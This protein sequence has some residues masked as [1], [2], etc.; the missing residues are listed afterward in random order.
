MNRKFSRR[1]FLRIG[2]YA[3]LGLSGLSMWSCGGSG[4]IDSA[5]GVPGPQ[6]L[7]DP[8]Y[9]A[10]VNVFLFGGNDG[11]NML[12]PTTQSKYDSYSAARLNLAVP[13]NQLLALNGI[14][15]DGAAYGAHPSC[16]E[17][18]DLFNSN[19]AALM[20]NVG[21]LTFP[22]V[23]ADYLAD[24]VPPRLF[25]H[26]DQQDQWQTAHPD[27]N[28]PTGWA[29]RIADV[30]SGA[31]GS[32]ELP[33]NVSIAGANLLQRGTSTNAFSLSASGA[34]QLNQ[35]AAT[36]GSA[37][38]RSSFDQILA[39]NNSHIF[40]RSY[41][42]TLDRGIRLNALLDTALK[43]APA[44]TTAFP[45][46]NSLAAQLQ[47]VAKLISIRDTLGAKR[48]IFFVSLGGFDTHDAQAADHP[49]LLQRL[50]Q[51]L[52]AFYSATVEL[53]IDS[54]VTSFTS[55]D[56]GRSLTING[57]GTDHGWSNHQWVV[58][59]AVNGA[60]IYGMPPSLIPNS[61]DD[62]VGGRFIPSS[63]VDQYGATLAKWF[64]VSDSNM[65][66]VFPNIGRFV[67]RDLGFM[68]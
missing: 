42:D 24:R 31:N 62:T 60:K 10:L 25:S 29:G 7:T 45:A 21:S 40:E 36:G 34:Q 23:R 49:V 51:A 20:S 19:K 3:G 4:G 67:S 39:L 13:Q 6:P 18:K 61:S 33:L 14:A 16:A 41:S 66:Y 63:A 52:Q 65:S 48:Q 30:L 35:L 43:S 56:F 26:N 37:N 12:V 57:N 38:L 44:F 17:L 55:S 11:Y 15:D 22:T 27:V 47:T 53:G 64:G 68:L 32:S 50:S 28:D 46:N 8:G 2:G 58:G 9:K 54:R 5:S 59:G 1:E